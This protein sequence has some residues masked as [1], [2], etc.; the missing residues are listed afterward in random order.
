[1]R[2]KVT[3]NRIETVEYASGYKMK[4]VIFSSVMDQTATEAQKFHSSSHPIGEI[5]MQIDNPIALAKFVPGRK[6]FVEFIETE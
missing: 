2:A 1:M 3:V 5:V 6:F 4:K